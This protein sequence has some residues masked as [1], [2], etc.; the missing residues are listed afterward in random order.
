[1]QKHHSKHEHHTPK[2]G[3]HCPS[4]GTDFDGKFCYN[5]GEKAYHEADFTVKKFLAHTLDM[6]THLDGKFLKSVKYIFIKPGFL[7]LENMRGARVKYAKPIQIFLLANVVFFLVLHFA[8]VTDYIPQATDERFRAISDFFVMRWLAPYEQSVVTFITNLTY[9][10]LHSSAL[11]EGD[12]VI[13]FGRNS[14]TYSKALI[15]TLIPLYAIVVYVFNIKNFRFFSGSLIFSAHFLAFQLAA[16]TVISAVLLKLLHVNILTP[17]DWLFFKTP[18][19]PVSIFL[20]SDRFQFETVVIWMPYLYLAFR[21]LFPQDHWFIT[22]LK[23]Y[24]IG[25]IFFCITFVIYKKLLILLNLWLM[26]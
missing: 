5:C 19:S 20:F 9:Q 6:F 4:C 2:A 23:T 3:H 12:F 18:V 1:M 16:Y 24:F 25:R 13:Q 7:T 21:R 11:S 17:L 10:K 22:L 15:V 8:Y 26:H 14:A